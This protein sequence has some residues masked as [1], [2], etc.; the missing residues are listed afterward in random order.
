[1][2]V[3]VCECVCVCLCVYVRQGRVLYSLSILLSRY[4]V[5]PMATH[6]CKHATGSTQASL[7]NVRQQRVCGKV[8]DLN[9]IKVFE[10]GG[11]P[12]Q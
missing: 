3:C 4:R 2:C 8:G 10:E 12:V 5:P 7:D 11:Q 9:T 6:T 1:M